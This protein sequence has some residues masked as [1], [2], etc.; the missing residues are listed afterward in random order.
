LS[1]VNVGSEL[2]AVSSYFQASYAVN[3]TK[4]TFGSSTTLHAHLFVQSI[5]ASNPSMP[6]EVATFDYVTVASTSTIYVTL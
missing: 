4:F 5:V 6:Y 1:S 3:F 2:V